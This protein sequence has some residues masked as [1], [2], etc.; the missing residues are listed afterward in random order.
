MAPRTASPFRT[1][2]AMVG[3]L[4]EHASA[5]RGRAGGLGGPGRCIA[6]STRF[7]NRRQADAA[8]EPDERQGPELEG[9]LPCKA[10]VEPTGHA[11]PRTSLP[12]LAPVEPAELSRR[13]L[14][15]DRE[16]SSGRATPHSGEPGP[17]SRRGRG[18]SEGGPGARPRPAPAPQSTGA[19]RTSLASSRVRPTFF[20]M[21][22]RR[23]CMN[24]GMFPLGAR[25]SRC[26]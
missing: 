19:P 10:R 6:S 17:P 16:D 18:C 15:G 1:V 8:G 12:P 23:Y 3:I 22:E 9:L 4:G 13:L 26:R 5:V 21:F 14:P 7:K 2:G 24:C 25:T 11:V 20:E